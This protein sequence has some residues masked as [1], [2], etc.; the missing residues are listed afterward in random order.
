MSETLPG[1]ARVVLH[2]AYWGPRRKRFR[3]KSWEAADLDQP[4]IGT[5]LLVGLVGGV[6]SVWSVWCQCLVLLWFVKGP[7]ALSITEC[8]GREGC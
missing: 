5:Q 7:W 3:G 4:Y 8:G 1:D 6:D 2:L